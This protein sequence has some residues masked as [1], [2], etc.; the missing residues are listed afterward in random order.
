MAN[1]RLSEGN[2]RALQFSCRARNLCGTTSRLRQVCRAEFQTQLWPFSWHF[3][4]EYQGAIAYIASKQ[5]ATLR[6][7]F[8]ALASRYAE[9]RSLWLHPL[10]RITPYLNYT[11]AFIWVK[12]TEQKQSSQ[13]RWKV[14]TVALFA[15][16]I[17]SWICRF[18]NPLKRMQETEPWIAFRSAQT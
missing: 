2:L 16:R 1:R 12:K 8:A 13:V 3:T 15:G 10:G 18:L 9:N 17:T 7:W 5:W 6:R 11:P 14:S 4:E